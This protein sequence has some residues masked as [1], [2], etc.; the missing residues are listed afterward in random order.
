MKKYLI[1]KVVEYTWNKVIQALISNV[2]NKGMKI[3]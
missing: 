3:E 2:G 1:K